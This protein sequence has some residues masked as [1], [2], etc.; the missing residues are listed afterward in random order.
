MPLSESD[1]RAKLIDPALMSAGWT[2]EQLK[3][4]VHITDGRLYLVG[5]EA[6]RRQPLW[7]DYVLYWK[8]VPIAVVE[9]KD[10]THHAAAGLQ[11][12]KAYAQRMDLLFAFST[13]G[14]DIV[15]FDYVSS[16][17]RTLRMSE[18]PSP[19]TLVA[20]AQQHQGGRLPDPAL[21]P[22]NTT[23]GL[24]PRYYQD[25]AI[26]R[27]LT[28]IENG[29]KRVL[30]ALATGTGKTF[31][32]SQL[33][34]K[35]YQT[36]RVSRV[37]FLADRVFLRNQAF[38]D[39]AFFSQQAGD[40]R[41]AIDGA[42][43]PHSAIYFGIYQALYALRDGRPLFTH[44]PKDFF[45]LIVIDECHRSGFGTW[46]DILDYFGN[47]IQIGL[48]ATP[49]RT[50]NIDTYAYFGEP[51]YE[52][53]LGQGIDDGFL[54][55]YKVHRVRTNL[56]EAGGVHV[57]DALVAGA[58]MFVPEGVDPKTFYGVSEFERKI[59][60]PDWTT[61]ICDH[62][63]A[64]LASGD[65]MERTLV[66]CVNMDHA[67]EVRQQ[68]Q[69]RFAH[70]G[71][72]DY[73]VRI[74]SD[75][76]YGAAL[77]EEFRDSYRATPVIATT[78]DLLSTGV[79][80]PSV[81][82]IVFI[83]P[84]GSTVVFKQIVGR[85]TR[86]D[87]V[88]D[89]KWFRIIDYTNATR[90]FDEWDRPPEDAQELTPQPWL[91]SIRLEVIDAETAKS[92]GASWAIA[93]SAPNQQMQLRL[94]DGQLVA[95]GLPE[96]PV[97]FHVGAPGYRSR[98]IRLTP[99]SDSEPPVAIV[100][101]KPLHESA[102]RILL[103][104]IEVEIADEVVLTVDAAGRQMTVEQYVAYARTIVTPHIKD[105]LDLVSSWLSD[106]ERK[107]LVDDLENNGVHLALLADLLLV[108]NADG[109]DVLDFLALTGPLI[110]RQ[111]RLEAFRN[112]N[113]QWLASFSAQ[114][115]TVVAE[116]AAAYGDGGIDQLSRRV[117]QLDRFRALG[118][119]VIVMKTFG[120]SAHFDLMLGELRRRIYAN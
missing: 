61:R 47:A 91:G 22:Y 78:V 96:V 1:T 110:T 70:L 114:R 113:A 43:S 6:H 25:V 107:K 32:A 12:A 108:H 53:S 42:I 38:N 105:R 111:E 18:F 79:D 62:L 34:W 2:E 31:I 52:Y 97:S 84:I 104:G 93:V 46:R 19:A 101:L 3:R 24:F 29:T 4:E 15:M 74:V 37:L 20:M 45:D 120:G 98:R 81:R 109:F 56:D 51:L 39:F 60:L 40:L 33:V 27:T 64:T 59:T 92:L 80:I 118:G 9:A 44:V 10:E 100:E 86:L 57:E 36:K 99:I 83:K 23:R 26:R 76:P 11:Q 41:Y 63:A 17:E 75:E 48:T 89:K 102:Q 82:N 49:K 117:L 69:N 14:R 115:Q 66:F 71:H 55:T 87:P 54:A 28:S 95:D 77:L 68:L 13:N 35:L 72:S 94:Q 7:A 88:I 21:Y 103:R 119:A 16:Q 112:R 30:L 106:H 73:A 8:S 50:D 67:L 58:D 90:L 116:L 85:G 5:A 65:P